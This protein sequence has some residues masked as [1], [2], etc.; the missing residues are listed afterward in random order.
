MRAGLKEGLNKPAFLTAL[1][2][3]GLSIGK[4]LGAQ[5]R[6]LGQMAVVG[7]QPPGNRDGIGICKVRNQ[8]FDMA[9]ANLN[10][11]KLVYIANIGPI[12]T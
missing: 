12:S 4:N 9:I 3:L 8:I 5:A 6:K 1:R 11:Q 10:V 2:I 7:K